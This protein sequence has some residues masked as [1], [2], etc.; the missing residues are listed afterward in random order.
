MG[1][2]ISAYQERRRLKRELELSLKCAKLLQIQN[3]NDWK[4]SVEKGKILLIGQK[5]AGVSTIRKQLKILHGNGFSSEEKLAYKKNIHSFILSNLRL[6]LATNQQHGFLR[7]IDESALWNNE[8]DS[9]IINKKIANLLKDIW[10]RPQSQDLWTMYVG[11]QQV[12]D[13]LS[14]YMSRIDEISDPTFVPSN[15][16]LLRAPDERTT[17]TLTESIVLDKVEFVVYDV[18]NL[19]GSQQK[20][21]PCFENVSAVILVVDSSDYELSNAVKGHSH[22]Q[23]QNNHLSPDTLGQVRSFLGRSD[24]KHMTEVCKF[25]YNTCKLPV[26]RLYK[27]LALFDEIINSKYFKS[28][29]RFLFLNKSD[30]FQKKLQTIPLSSVFQNFKGPGFAVEA[31]KY[32][33]YHP[34]TFDPERDFIAEMFL[35]TNRHY[36]SSEVYRY[37][38]SALDTPCM[39]VVF[40][41]TKDIM[42]E[43]NLRGFGCF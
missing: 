28:S 10:D 42:V 21:I 4:L 1:S 34:S 23:A 6:L 8:D 9:E 32:S 3:I 24:I 40:N 37:W 15:E 12:Y 29:F 11:N 39:N 41:A 20:W 35:R 18:N 36:A 27:Q 13:A 31:S 22:H 26:S 19:Q 14:W 2:A 5:G 17:G 25:W 7:N 30:L 43:S 33:D 38:V 16:D